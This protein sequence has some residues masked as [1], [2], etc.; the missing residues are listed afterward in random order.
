MGCRLPS[1]IA[2]P[3]AFALCATLAASVQSQQD[4]PN[5]PIRLMTPAAQGGTTDILA[6]VIGAR[7]AEVFKQNVLVENRASA[8]GV[9]AGE[10]TANAPADGY[11]LL[12]AYHQHTVNAALNPKLPYHAVNSFTPITQLT[13]AGLLLVVNPATPAKDLE[14]FLDWT[15][16]FKG[17]LNFGSAGNGSGGHL[18]GE[19]FKQMTGVKAEHVPYKGMGPALMDLVAGQYQFS[20]AGMQA[21]QSLARGGKLRA[22]AV[23]TPRRI[24]A[25]ADIPA[26]AERLPGFE[27]VGW[28]GIIGPPK[29]PPAIVARLH[30]ELVKILQQQEVR[31]RIIAD[32][33]EPVGSAPELFRQFMLADLE[34]WAKVAKESGAKLD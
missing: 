2:S 29:L 8:S 11:T 20:F 12:L 7:L 3:M 26:V 31:D 10:M 30:S 17:A 28:Y 18:A 24:A 13:T 14:G 9:I 4:Y 16:N 1:R 27:V 19:L 22:I 6:R 21:A 23:T 32:G 34:K 33:A 5:R 15:K 25:L